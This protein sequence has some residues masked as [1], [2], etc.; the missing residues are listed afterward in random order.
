[1]LEGVEA[2]IGLAG[3][4]GVAVDGDY[5]AFFVEGVA[6]GDREKGTG[7]RDQ[8]TCGVGDVGDSLKEA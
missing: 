1:M 2:E 7:I 3:G 8:L 4:V 5:A 6:F